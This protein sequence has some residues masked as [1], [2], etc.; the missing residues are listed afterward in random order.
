MAKY[1]IALHGI[2]LSRKYL[3][4]VKDFFQK[5][6][7]IV[8]DMDLLGFGATTVQNRG[9]I[10][11]FHEYTRSLVQVSREIR[12]Q[13]LQAKIFVWGENLGATIALMY[14]IEYPQC[15][16]GIVA[17]NP[18][19]SLELGFSKMDIAKNHMAS[20]IAPN[21]RIE[22]PFLLQDLTDDE[23]IAE[24]IASDEARCTSITARFWGA[25][26]RATVFL[27]TDA[28]RM[29]VPF[30]IQYS[31]GSHF[32]SERAVEHFLGLASSPLKLK[33]GIEG[34][35]L[36]SLSKKREDIYEKALS[37]FDLCD[38]QKK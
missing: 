37:F 3:F 21:T 9:D 34:P 11:D 16:S 13:D 18:L 10:S 14:G 20:Q 22:F 19:L 12:Q 28:R 23:H 6:G 7:F 27:W 8:R 17:V 25:L 26:F 15:P 36:L 4:Y 1:L 5:K 2:G 31:R 30:L 33:E 38:H 32:V 24:T 35:P 29:Q